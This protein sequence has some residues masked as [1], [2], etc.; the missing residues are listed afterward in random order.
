MKSERPHP[1]QDKLLKRWLIGDANWEEERMLESQAQDDPFLADAMEGYRSLPEEEHAEAVTKLK[2]QLRRRAQSQRHGAGFYL[3]RIA[4]VGAVL[5]AAWMVFQQFGGQSPNFDSIAKTE[6]AQPGEEQVAGESSAEET[7]AEPT[8][9]EKPSNAPEASTTVE[10]PAIAAKEDAVKK[11]KRKSEA[12]GFRKATE[13]VA[14]AAKKEAADVAAKKTSPAIES[15]N[16]P[17]ASK[18]VDGVAVTEFEA[19]EKPAEPE[20]IT[21]E[22][23]LTA[24]PV[25]PP[26]TMADDAVMAFDEINRTGNSAPV[27]H[28]I[29]GQVTDDFGD[30]LTGASVYIETTSEGTVTDANGYFAIET[31]TAQPNL[32]ISYIGYED[33]EMAVNDDEFLKVK[34]EENPLAM[35]EVA[36]TAMEKR[37]NAYFPN[38]RPKGGFRKFEKYVKKNLSKPEAA[39]EAGVSGQVLLRFRIQADGSL[40]DFEVLRPLGHGC[41][42]EAIR[43]LTE[44]PQW[45]ATPNTIATYGVQF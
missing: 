14:E 4:A 43:L 17:E 30:P 40:S 2:A 19:P 29:V 35:E 32:K 34:M 20:T 22:T 3:I 27:I 24:L 45:E 7:I 12:E 44:G 8:Q 11:A 37:S 5:L 13:E 31:K 25:S 18:A 42:E 21:E 15:D 41:D 6:A 26:P 23:E 39:V 9:E 16:A 10:P 33:R 36:V 38:P 28:K 1:D